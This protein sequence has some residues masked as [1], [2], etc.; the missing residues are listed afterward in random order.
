[1]LTCRQVTDQCD[2]LLAGE[3]HGRQL[4]SVRLHL[5]ICRHCRRYIHYMRRML[6]ALPGI[7]RRA[8]DD[9]VGQVMRSLHERPGQRP[10]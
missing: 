5:L 6:Q 4:W 9:E 3:L 7:R 10:S 8:S 2:A 1:M